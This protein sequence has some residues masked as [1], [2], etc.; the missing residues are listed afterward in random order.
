MDEEKYENQ[1]VNEPVKRIL[2]EEELKIEKYVEES[3]KGFKDDFHGKLQN[4]QEQAIIQ[5]Q[6]IIQPPKK[7]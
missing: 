6:N 2:N 4:A 1:I 5:A 3:L 7:K